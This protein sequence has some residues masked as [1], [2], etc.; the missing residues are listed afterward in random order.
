MIAY[1]LTAMSCVNAIERMNAHSAVDD[2]N[3]DSFVR[4]EASSDGVTSEVV[5]DVPASFSCFRVSLYERRLSRLDSRQMGG[6]L[7]RTDCLGDK[8]GDEGGVRGMSTNG[9][10]CAVSIS[11]EGTFTS[12]MQ[13]IVLSRK[14]VLSRCK[15]RED[16]ERDLEYKTDCKQDFVDDSSRR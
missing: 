16:E 14:V 11:A 15:E 8:F 3:R 9:E 4:L 1:A 2:R 12:N 13:C 5:T 10:L 7:R 6:G